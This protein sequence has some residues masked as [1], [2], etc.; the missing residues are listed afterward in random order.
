M[1]T[2]IRHWHMLRLIPRHPRTIDAPTLHARLAELDPGLNVSRRTVERD[3]NE[4]S[5]TFALVSFPGR[6]QQWCWSADAAALDVPGMDLVAALT[7]RM[8]EEYLG[9]MLPA[10]CVASL[11]P[12]FSRARQLLDGVGGKGLAA[13]PAKIEVVPRSMPLL[14]P[15][16]ASGVL[17]SVT[18]ALLRD[19]RCQVVYKRRGEEAR[20]LIL[21]PLGL[22]FND[23]VVYLVASVFDYPDVRLFALH[24]CLEAGMLNEPARQPANFDL[25][26]YIAEGALG[27]PEQRGRTLRLKTR[28][29]A[30]AGAH[31][32]ESPLSQE[33]KLTELADGR[34]LIE[35]E[36][37][38]TPQLRWWLLGFG[39]RVE[40]LEPK[41]LREEFAQM[42]TEMSGLY[43]HSET[44]E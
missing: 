40:I 14:P 35:A 9:R 42:A 19:Q 10:H 2:I 20:E 16:I 1:D 44:A 18:E 33:Q 26:R 22:V 3:L 7:F 41:G 11:A 5:T 4:L 31:L 15:A 38:D 34:L 21:N 25:Q 23:P 17:E 28:F 32:Y 24:R 27:F 39:P 29:T 8:T 13:W 12:H 30:A 43:T 6:P 36:V 37:A